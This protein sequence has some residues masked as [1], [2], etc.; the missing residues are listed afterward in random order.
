MDPYLTA[1][2]LSTPATIFAIACYLSNRRA[3]RGVAAGTAAVIHPQM[4]VYGRCFSAAWH[5]PDAAPSARAAPAFGRRPHR[6]SLPFRL[7]T[8]T[9][10]ARE[11][12]FS[13]TYFFVST[14]T[15][16]EW[17]GIFAPLAL[18]WWFSVISPRRTLPGF[19]PWRQP[20][21]IRPGVHR[22]RRGAGDSRQP[23][24]LQPPATHAEFPSA[25]RHLLRS[26]GRTD[27][28][29]LDQEERLAL[30]RPVCS[31]GGSHVA[32]AGERVPRQ[33][34]CGVAGLEQWQHLDFRFSV[35]PLH[36][37][38]EAVFA[39]DPN[40]M[41]LPGEDAHGFRAVAERSVLAD[42]VKD[43]GAVSLFP[44]LA[45][46]WEN[47]WAPSADSIALRRPIFRGCSKLSGNLD[48]DHATRPCR[49]H[50][51]L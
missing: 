4:S 47:R 44:K 27:R 29:V 13:R 8:R 35:D 14:W 6:T 31:A 15:W 26:A 9:G 32:A 23:G 17:I 21:S 24:E 38:K 30:G 2:S 42:N 1:R 28:R 39:L 51:S 34:A 12:L 20:G 49:P 19:R 5:W 50:L 46:E 37:P 7:R 11:A 25:V 41:V 16:Y 33:P 40:Y 43:S 18:L 48:P 45:A 22:A 10:A 36:T 3:G